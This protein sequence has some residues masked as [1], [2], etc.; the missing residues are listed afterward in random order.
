[1]VN[2]LKAILQTQASQSGYLAQSVCFKWESHKVK[3]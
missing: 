3:E 1:M 2:T